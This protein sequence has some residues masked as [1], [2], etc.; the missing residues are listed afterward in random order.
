MQR[1]LTALGFDTKQT[2][3]FNDDTRSVLK[4]WQTARG[5]PS[6]GY[7]NKN[8]HKALLAEIVAAPATASDTS[9]KPARRAANAPQGSAPAPQHR[10]NPGD[11]AGAAFVGG[12]V[13][14]MMG[15]MFRR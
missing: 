9:Q 14:G 11:A 8:Q 2:G 15:G 3:V 13:G 10:S 1:R 6:S 12:V 4:R 5:Y 7:L